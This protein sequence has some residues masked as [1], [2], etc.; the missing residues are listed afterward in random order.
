MSDTDKNKTDFVTVRETKR[1]KFPPVPTQGELGHTHPI[2][3]PKQTVL[4]YP[5]GCVNCANMVTTYFL[6]RKLRLRSIALKLVHVDFS[7]RVF[8]TIRLRL[9]KPKAMCLVFATG[10]VV[11][12]G[13]TS[14]AAS[15][16]IAALVVEAIRKCGVKNITVTNVKIR[17]RLDTVR[18][19]K[20]IDLFKV[21]DEQPGCSYSPERFTGAKFKVFGETLT[22]SFFSSGAMN[23]AG[24]RV[25]EQTI[26]HYNTMVNNV[27]QGCFVPLNSPEL[28]AVKLR[29]Q[30][31]GRRNK[32]HKKLQ[33]DEFGGDRSKTTKNKKAKGTNRTKS[34]KNKKNTTAPSRK[35]KTREPDPRE[36]TL[37]CNP[38]DPLENMLYDV[39][40][41]E[42]GNPIP[43]L[44]M[45]VDTLDLDN[46]LDEVL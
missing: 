40:Y 38:N 18:I 3:Y 30:H 25:P 15:L 11:I 1:I 43:T 23:I 27:L 2:I 10:K 32:K 22:I 20:G 42:N 5:D 29:A 46:I 19:G 33:Q 8:G 21:R 35:Q 24:A 26:H 13:T 34:N 39:N 28:E 4:M 37:M 31:V 45:E 44:D 14:K 41:T 7:K 9:L 17:N 16:R 36:N 6:G 12:G